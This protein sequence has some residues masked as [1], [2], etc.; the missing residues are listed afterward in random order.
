MLQ[1][2]KRKE[3]IAVVLIFI[4]ALGVRLHVTDFLQPI[5]INSDSA[6]YH[7]A[8]KD[9]LKY[10]MLI[11]DGTGV[12]FN[13]EAAP[14]P[15][16]N[17]MPGLPF[18]LAG[19][20]QIN[21]DLPLVYFVQLMLSM[22]ILAL[23]YKLTKTLRLSAMASILTLALAAVYPA[24][25]YNLDKL[26]T[27]TLFTTLLTANFYY[28]IRILQA[29]QPPTQRLICPSVLLICA[30]MIRPQALP[31]LVV[32]CFLLLLY[33]KPCVPLKTRIACCGT[34]VGTALVF[35]IPLWIRNWITFHDFWLLAG[36]GGGPRI[37]GC[38][39][40]FLDMA[41]TV[42]KS[43]AE[44]AAQSSST[45]Y[46]K[47]RLFGFFNFMWYDMWDENLVHPFRMLKAARLIH[48]LV[49][50]PVVA[51]IPILVRKAKPAV[52]FLASVPILFTL[53]CM[54][55]HGLP[56]YVFPSLPCVFVLTGV[57]IDKLIHRFSKKTAVSEEPLPM[58][59]LAGCVDRIF[60]ICYLAFS[61]IFSVILLYSVF[62]F[63]G[64]V[65]TEMS[66]FFLNRTY[67]ISA[68]DVEWLPV[69]EEQELAEDLSLWHIDNVTPGMDGTFQGM[70]DATPILHVQIPKR[71]NIEN[72]GE[73]EGYITKV[74]L[75]IPGGYWYDCA[76]VYWVG[77]N[78]PEFS[79]SYVYGRFPRNVFHSKQTVYIADNVSSLMIVPSC[80]RG[81]RFSIEGI[82]ITKYQ[83]PIE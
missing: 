36:D 12:V 46:L 7:Y 53:M 64:S 57:L 17:I 29:D 30:V 48:P 5:A 31:F 26:L 83:V 67:G 73:N 40:Y 79:E 16:A 60:R 33:L 2:C 47:W 28:F 4:M 22:I 61:C 74:E 8:A 55:F 20:Y 75:D 78:T 72:I 19:L 14:T 23:V 51:M 45:T 77:D 76:T 80:F 11:N 27:E 63:A 62:V 50:V 71:Q 59:K 49:V 6:A 69:V 13:E 34:M 82:H 66:N 3:R 39:P 70:W 9:L 54:P 15:A 58:P 41:S 56:R 43:F 32:E 35:L 25:C 44:L 68:S 10:G 52:L 18:F 81:T 24:F 21:D 1:A 42:G 37:W 38:Q 65:K